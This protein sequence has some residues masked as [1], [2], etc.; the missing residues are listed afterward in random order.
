MFFWPD[1]KSLNLHPTEIVYRQIGWFHTIGTQPNIYQYLVPAALHLK[2]F[3]NRIYHTHV[4]RSSWAR[5]NWSQMFYTSQTPP[6]PWE[7][8]PFPQSSAPG[9]DQT[10]QPGTVMPSI[11][12]FGTF[13]G[14]ETSRRGKKAPPPQLGSHSCRLAANTLA[15]Q[16]LTGNI[17][18]CNWSPLKDL[19]AILGW[20]SK[21]EFMQ[22]GQDLSRGGALRWFL[23]NGN[24]ESAKEGAF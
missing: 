4:N 11:V 12:I 7:P 14:S 3:K 10:L 5:L 22:V 8:P 20:T 6:N 21:G 2:S 9:V 15:H 19:T 1:D 16:T 17:P 23:K 18:L 13:L 24:D